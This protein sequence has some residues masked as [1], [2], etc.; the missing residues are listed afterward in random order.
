MPKIRRRVTDRPAEQSSCSK[1]SRPCWKWRSASG[2][3]LEFH[4]FVLWRFEGAK[5]A[6]RLATVTAPEEHSSWD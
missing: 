3:K 5:I 1:R 6:E 2:K 4:G